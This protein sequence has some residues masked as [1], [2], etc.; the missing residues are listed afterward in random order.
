[1]ELVS[2]KDLVREDDVYMNRGFKDE[3]EEE[4]AP[5]EQY[6]NYYPCGLRNNNALF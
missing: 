1:M 2:E 5:E 3:E 4:Y 6:N